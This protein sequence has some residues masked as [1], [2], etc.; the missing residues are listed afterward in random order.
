MSEEV[1]PNVLEVRE[2]T[3]FEEILKELTDLQKM[4][5]VNE[6]LQSMPPVIDIENRGSTDDYVAKPLIHNDE[7]GEIYIEFEEIEREKSDDE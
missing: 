6:I 4:R 5:L 1:V 3:M 2:L 7:T